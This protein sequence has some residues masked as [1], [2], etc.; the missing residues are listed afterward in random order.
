MH[1]TTLWWALKVLFV[2]RLGETQQIEKYYE[3]YSDDPTSEPKSFELSSI[4]KLFKRVNCY[5]GVFEY[6]V[7]IPTVFELSYLYL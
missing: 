1:D 5:M 4:H 6:G 3:D 7:F 2:I